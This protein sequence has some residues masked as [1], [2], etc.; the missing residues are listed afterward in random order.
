MTERTTAIFDLPTSPAS[1]DY[2]VIARFDWRING[3]RFSWRKCRM[4]TDTVGCRY[5]WLTD[6]KTPDVS[7]L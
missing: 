2:D 7:W 4:V 3:E 1:D 5:R 6:E